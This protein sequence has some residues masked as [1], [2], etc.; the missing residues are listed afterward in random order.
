MKR[1]LGSM[2]AG[3]MHYFIGDIVWHGFENICPQHGSIN[4]G[5][6]KTAET[7]WPKPSDEDEDEPF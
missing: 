4:C 5:C 3:M 2:C 1:S 7:E 6:E